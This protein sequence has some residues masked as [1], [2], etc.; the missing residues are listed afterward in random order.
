VNLPGVAP[1]VPE[2]GRAQE[3]C[4]AAV[5]LADRLAGD[6]AADIRDYEAIHRHILKMA[7]ELSDGIVAQFPGRF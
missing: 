1:I 5:S 2:A 7:D 4:R 3:A 6:Y